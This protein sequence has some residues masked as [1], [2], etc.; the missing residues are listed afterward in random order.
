MDKC[1]FCQDRVSNGEQPACAA[2]CPTGAIR[3][4][5]RAELVKEGNE[6]VG[7][8]GE[9][10]AKAIFYGE[11]ELGG[12]HVMYVI[13][14]TPEAYGLPVDPEIPAP[15]LVRDVLKLFGVGTVVVTVAGLGLNYIIAR[16]KIMTSEPSS[17]E[18]TKEERR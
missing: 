5:K 15:V 9:A 6:R 2:A 8:L 1:T 11:K 12:L 10:G 7:T 4:G 3:F 16:K 18:D 17:T 14:D 13:D